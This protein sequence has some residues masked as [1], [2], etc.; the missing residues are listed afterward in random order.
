M[1]CPQATPYTALHR[2]DAV[3]QAL[4]NCAKRHNIPA[5]REPH[6]Y[7]YD[8]GK[9]NKPDITFNTVPKF[10]T[11]V[12]IVNPER[13]CAMDGPTGAAAATAKYKKHAKAANDMN[14]QFIPFAMETFGHF[15]VSAAK[16]VARLTK[17]LP[18]YIANEF[19][20]EV[21]HD[22]STALAEGVATS[23]LQAHHRVTEFERQY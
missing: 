12:T 2:H 17:E 23:F 20:Q 3:V 8:N 10:V 14:H 9:D 13:N 16:V 4:Y 18:E 7:I 15:D 1:R 11:D 19:R 21:F 5:T 22:C 6:F